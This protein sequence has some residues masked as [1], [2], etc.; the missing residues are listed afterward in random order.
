MK[1]K[2]L[3]ILGLPIAFMFLGVAEFVGLFDRHDKK[4]S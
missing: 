3:V 2:L 1:R 4:I